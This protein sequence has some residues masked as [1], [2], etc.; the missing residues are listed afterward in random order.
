MLIGAIVVFKVN[1][2]TLI[3]STTFIKGNNFCYFPF[4]SLGDKALPE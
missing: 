4:A 1:G 3:C 2:N